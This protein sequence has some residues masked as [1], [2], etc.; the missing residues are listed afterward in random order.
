MVK[1]ISFVALM[2]TLPLSLFAAEATVDMYIATD[3]GN[4]DKIGQVVIS[5][6]D[7]GLVFTPNLKGVKTGVHG[8][9]VHANGDCGP[10]TAADGKITPA[11]AAGGHVDPTK[12][13]AHTGPDETT[14]H[15]GDLPAV[16]ADANGDVTYPV[17]A[18]KIKKLD[19]IKGKALMLHVG[20]DNHDD[21]PAPLG[22]GGARMACGIIK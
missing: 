6:S 3:K 17:L 8:F 10:S 15:L 2:A 21:H 9:H 5:E 11:G 20:G 19:E 16:Y 12:T 18:P 1:K 7:F 22:G 14:G 13:K 4:G